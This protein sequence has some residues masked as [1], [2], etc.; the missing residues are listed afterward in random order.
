MFSKLLNLSK[1][2]ILRFQFRDIYFQLLKNSKFSI[3]SKLFNLSKTL[4]L[5][6]KFRDI[7]FQPL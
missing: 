4:I 6:F 2:L 5:R 7:Y 3:F 1:I